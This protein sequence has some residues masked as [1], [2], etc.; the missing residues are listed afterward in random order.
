MQRRAANPL[1]PCWESV[2]SVAHYKL[3]LVD[4]VEASGLRS[5]R[6]AAAG[7]RLPY[8]THHKRVKPPI[9]GEIVRPGAIACWA[10]D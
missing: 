9:S 10:A 2:A 3:A 7:K 6:G 4:N 8:K 5:T 1:N